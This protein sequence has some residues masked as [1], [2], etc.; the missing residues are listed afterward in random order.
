MYFV[1]SFF[2]SFFCNF[3]LM[4]LFPI[5]VWLLTV[6]LLCS[7]RFLLIEPMWVS[8]SY[9]ASSVM[10]SGELSSTVAEIWIVVLQVDCPKK[11]IIFPSI[12]I[13]YLLEIKLIQNYTRNILGWMRTINLVTKTGKLLFI[14]LLIC[15]C[16]GRVTCK[17]YLLI[18]IT[19][20]MFSHFIFC[21]SCPLLCFRILE[22]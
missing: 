14:V 7:S 17:R 16:F 12:V 2:I 18:F 11:K 1:A 3:N 20:L 6:F 5:V 4:H 22:Q 13:V 21:F 8:T 9:L 10:P 19:F 15:F